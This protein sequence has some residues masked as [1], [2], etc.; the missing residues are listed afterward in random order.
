MAISQYSR[1][2]VARP[3]DIVH[4]AGPMT[5]AVAS[6]RLDWWDPVGVSHRIPQFLLRNALGPDGSNAVVSNACVPAS[7]PH[8][9]Y[10]FPPLFIQIIQSIHR[11]HYLDSD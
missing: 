10:C 3:L 5:G 6:Y 8:S 9:T 7:A 4:S 2:V 1:T 11:H